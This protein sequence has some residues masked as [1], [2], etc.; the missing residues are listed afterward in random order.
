MLALG[1]LVFLNSH[2]L[3]I[4][5]LNLS[6][7]YRLLALD[8]LLVLNVIEILRWICLSKLIKVGNVI[9]SLIWID[10]YE[11]NILVDK[12]LCPRN[13]V[14]IQKGFVVVYPANSVLVMIPFLL[15]R[16]CYLK[17]LAWLMI[18]HIIYNNS[19][20]AW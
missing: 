9:L 5:Y 2:L 11:F 1:Y 18:I 12:S 7:R 14:L 17:T 6:I 4:L 8:V 20:K 19:C 13:I 10:S 16:L 15:T 3:I